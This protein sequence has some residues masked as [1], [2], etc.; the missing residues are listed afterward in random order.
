MTQAQR[1]AYQDAYSKAYRAYKRAGWSVYSCRVFGRR[2]GK[3]AAGYTAL[4]E[5]LIAVPGV[6]NPASDRFVVSMSELL[7]MGGAL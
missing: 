2:A 7:E 6:V 4:R 5:A 1:R 3:L